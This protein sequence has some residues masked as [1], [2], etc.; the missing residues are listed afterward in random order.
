MSGF[1]SYA[2]MLRQQSKALIVFKMNL[3]QAK[4]T[5]AE[6]FPTVSN[7]TSVS[8]FITYTYRNEMRTRCL[9]KQPQMI[10]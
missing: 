9:H 1:D 3:M 5:T 6:L 8:K 2:H 4:L 7:S 10:P